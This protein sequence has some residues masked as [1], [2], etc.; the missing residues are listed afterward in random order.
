MKQIVSIVAGLFLACVSS[1]ASEV[2]DRFPDFV[3]K[4]L[5]GH[6]VSWKQ[7]QGKVVV[8]NLWMTTC[9]P[10]KKE[11]PMLQGLQDKYASRGVVFV[12]ISTDANA[13]T[14]D[15]FARKI[16][17]KYTLLID[18]PLYTEESEQKKFGF[19]GLPTTFVVD[20]SGVIRKKVVG[21][22][23]ENEIEPALLELLLN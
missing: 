14:A 4:D 5:K 2:G 11:M 21:F 6:T 20:G 17:I 3:L 15:K 8:V 22:T 10:C 13:R 19:L 23:Y 9:P 7:F 1:S 12:G 18:P 16:G